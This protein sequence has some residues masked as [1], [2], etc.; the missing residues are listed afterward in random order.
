MEF[1]HQSI[2]YHLYIILLFFNECNILCSISISYNKKREI[3]NI[4]LL[5][6]E[7]VGLLPISPIVM[8]QLHFT[9]V[10]WNSILV[11]S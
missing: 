10:N 3:V 9:L 1:I 8:N 7:L 6:L 11:E 5:L 2:I 4:F